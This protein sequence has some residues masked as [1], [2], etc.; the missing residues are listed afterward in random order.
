[1]LLKIFY[2]IW[3]KVIMS[4]YSKSDLEKLAKESGFIRDNLEKV[5]RLND[6]LIYFNTNP[7]L[8]VGRYD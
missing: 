8:V 2:L 6:I 3:N 4:L 5:I 1:M 7:L